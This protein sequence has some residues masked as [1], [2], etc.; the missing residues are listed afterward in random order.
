MR[1]VFHEVF[2]AIAIVYRQLTQEKHGGSGEL[3]V[4]ASSDTVIPGAKTKCP[5]REANTTFG[6][7][8]PPSIAKSKMVFVG[9]D[10]EES[11]SCGGIYEAPL[12]S[13]NH[14]SLNVLVDLQTAVPGQQED[15]FTRIGEGLSYDGSAVAFW[16]SWGDAMEEIIL[17]CPEHGN[18]DRMDFCKYHDNNTINGTDEIECYH[19]TKEVPVHQG[20]F[21]YSEGKI[22]LVAEANKDTGTDFVFWNYSGKPP[23]AGTT[24]EY[25]LVCTILGIALF[26]PK[27]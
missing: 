9:L 13:A 26:D 10:V 14:P 12:N 22:Q 7:T 19:Q 18:K 5:G 23:S 6:S 20:V 4:V 11:P 1:I 8:A 16:A 3:Y 17:C 24:G 15:T 27:H 25:A 21:V 2:V